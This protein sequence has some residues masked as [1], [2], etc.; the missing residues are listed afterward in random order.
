[1][2]SLSFAPG[3][4][5]TSAAGEPMP[6]C[7]AEPPEHVTSYRGYDHRRC[8]HPTPGPPGYHRC[9]GDLACPARLRARL[10]CPYHEDLAYD[11][12]PHKMY[13]ALTGQPAGSRIPA[14]TPWHAL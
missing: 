4:A 14:R 10:Y 7:V 3:H 12:D 11:H 8:A 13:E 9:R 1:M 5:A 2:T 6:G